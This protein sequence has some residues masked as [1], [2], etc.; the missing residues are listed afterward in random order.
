MTKGHARKVDHDVGRGLY[1]GNTHWQK[2][3]AACLGDR[4]V[5]VGGET[6]D[7]LERA[8]SAVSWCQAT[9]GTEK[10]DRD[11]SCWQMWPSM[12]HRRCFPA[13]ASV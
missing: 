11:V 2:Y 6:G 1:E 4:L 7:E 12:C 13:V 9:D 8:Y 10:H 3:G 5:V